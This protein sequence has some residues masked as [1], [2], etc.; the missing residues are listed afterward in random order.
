MP[1]SGVYIICFLKCVLLI[2]EEINAH[3]H[4]LLS[5]IEAMKR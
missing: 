5:L 2:V 3:L 4:Y 1:F